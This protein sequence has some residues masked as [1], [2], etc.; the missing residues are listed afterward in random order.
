VKTKCSVTQLQQ[1]GLEEVETFEE[2]KSSE[3]FR[4]FFPSLA[5][6]HCWVWWVA[7]CIFH[8]IVIV[9][10][11]AMEFEVGALSVCLF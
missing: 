1:A 10:V 4:Q 11:D 6:Q 8:C 9:V 5:T 7:D 3:V 2:E